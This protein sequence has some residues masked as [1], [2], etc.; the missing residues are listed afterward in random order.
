MKNE[1]TFAEH[2]GF[3][4]PTK[5]TPEVIE[6]QKEMLDMKPR[7]T[8]QRKRREVIKTL[9]EL[10][11]NVEEAD[12]VINENYDFKSIGEKIAFLKGMFDVRF[13]SKHDAEGVSE[14]KSAEM[15]YWAMLNAIII[16]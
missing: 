13:V 15:D 11:P 2:K 5:Q 10:S 9:I 8:F 16:T 14:E 1:I 12:K 7:K 3:Y 4:Q 6:K